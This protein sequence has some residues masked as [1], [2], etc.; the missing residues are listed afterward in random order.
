MNTKITR[1][2]FPNS[3]KIFV[4]GKLFPI[5]VA[6]RQV[7]LTDSVKVV[8]GKRVRTPHDPVVL[9]DTSGPYTDPEALIDLELGLPRLRESWI[10]SDK[11]IEQLTQ[12]TSEYGRMRED[13]AT[14]DKIRFKNRHLPYKAKEGK[15]VTQMALARQGIITPEME[16]VAIRENMNNEELGIKTHITPEFVRDEIAKGRA[17]IPA[18]INHPEAEPMIIGRNFLVKINTNIGNSAM[19]S[20]IE[21]EIEKAVW[22]C[23]WGGDT[24]M[25]LSTGDNI[26][27]TREWIIRNCPVPVG[28]V[29]IYQAL[30]KVNGKV[31]DLTWEIYRDTLIEQAEQGVDYF[32]IHAG[33]KLA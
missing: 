33:I 15:V 30:E 12:L 3:E 9:Y 23:R 13:D 25:D 19:S 22:S 21:E 8:D 10:K 20:G 29:P 16:Y 24:L 31:E 2:P 28:T 7:N 27:E 14:L 26:H 11:N 18:N 4:A 6:M 17:I 1:T 5:Q 32:T